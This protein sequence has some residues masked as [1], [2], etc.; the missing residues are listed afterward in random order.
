MSGAG[1]RTY[2]IHKLR[3]MVVGAHLAGSGVTTRGDA[4][5][6][7]VGRLLRRTKLD[8]LPQLWNVVVGDMSL[9]GPRPEDP[10]YVDRYTAEQRIVLTV[11]PGLTSPASLVYR[12]EESLLDGP[13]WESVYTD[14][15]LPHKLDIDARFVRELT[16]R[17]YLG[18][19]LRTVRDV[20]RGGDPVPAPPRHA[21]VARPVLPATRTPTE[22]VS[23]DRTQETS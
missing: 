14:V 16:V 12:D 17:S 19:L 20:V 9:V 4:R 21:G 8:E 5:V 7:R 18:V 10:R 1:G 2:R 15:V 11:R 22:A 6:T 13:D 3:T 23:T